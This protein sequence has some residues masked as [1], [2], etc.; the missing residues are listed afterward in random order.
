MSED[1]NLKA[2]IYFLTR[3]PKYSVIKPYTLRYRPDNGFPQTNVERI[4][5][6][7]EIH[8]LRKFPELNYERCGFKMAR[9]KGGENKMRYEDYDDIDKVETVHQREVVD[10]VRESLGAREVVVCDYVIRRRDPDWPISKGGSYKWQQPAS[11]AHIDHTY[12]AGA[13]IVRD[14]YGEKAD[15]VLSGRWQCVNVWHPL[16]GPLVD[17]PLA[18]CDGSTV[19]FEND[20]MAGDIVDKDAVFENTQVHFNPEQRWYYLS[21]QVPEELLI[22]KNADSGEESGGMPGVP[23]ASFDNPGTTDEDVRRESI[24]FRLLVRW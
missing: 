2:S 6:E 16:Q 10:A 24:E 13:K 19:D 3:S 23:H 17:W 9:M 21:D 14:V 4:L 7:I 1:L 8:D 18:L 5:H 22:F 15:L 12:D 11:A 20:T